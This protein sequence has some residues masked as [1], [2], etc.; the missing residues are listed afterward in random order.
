MTTN[1]AIYAGRKM[2]VAMRNARLI[3]LREKR[4]VKPGW[5]TKYSNA[6]AQMKVRFRTSQRTTIESPPKD[7]SMRHIL[8]GPLRNLSCNTVQTGASMDQTTAN[9]MTSLRSPRYLVHAV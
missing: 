5:E 1:V 9:M 4:R 7:R 3:C 6:P 8:P 2:H